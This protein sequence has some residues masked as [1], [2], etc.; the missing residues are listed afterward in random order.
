MSGAPLDEPRTPPHTEHA[1]EALLRIA[2]DEP[3]RHELVTLGPLTNVATALLVD[4]DLLTRFTQVTMMI[5]AA[6]GRGNVAA[7]GEFNAWA[8]PEAAKIVFEAAGPKRMVG[9]DASRKYAVVTEADEAEL[10]STGRYGE[11]LCEINRA[12]RTWGLEVTGI[13]GYDLPDPLAMAVAIDPSIIEQASRAHVSV[14][15][16]ESTRGQTYLD[17]RLPLQPPNTTVVTAVHERALMRQLTWLLGR[18]VAAET[19][20]A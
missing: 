6:D 18:A 9:W 3:N 5:G 20:D 14:S 4:P 1:V 10:R 2:R 15:T 8:D 13:D 12:V 16:D 17:H 19:V 11:F 7:T